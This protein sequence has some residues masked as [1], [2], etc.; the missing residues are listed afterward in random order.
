[1][2]RIRLAAV[3]GSVAVAVP[4]AGIACLRQ[5]QGNPALTEVWDPE[6]R[7][8]RPG[9][10][11]APPSDA[12]VLFD[13]ANLTGWE[14]T[15]GSAATW[16]VA[17]GVMT[18]ASGSGAIRTKHGFGD[19]QLHIE[20]RTP[21]DVR[22]DNQEPGNSGI[23]LQARYELQVLNSFGN[24]TYANGQAGS[25]YKQFI[26]LVNASRG[27]GQWQTY[28]VVFTAPRFGADG[29]MTA[30]AVFTVFHNGVLIQNHVELKGP[31]VYTGQP[32][33]VAHGER[34]PLMLQDHGEPV[35]FR[36][37]WLREM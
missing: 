2:S 32:K 34:E 25:I 7:V 9:D 18:V 15:D 3:L 22:G 13:G 16:V 14:H 8:V 33:Y 28:D 23:F 17:D 26:P 27:P 4:L 30:P 5:S 19:C 35:S 37:I 29:A 1:M 31:T 12:I 11:G 20:W 24:R 6:P 36:N 21:S 10:A